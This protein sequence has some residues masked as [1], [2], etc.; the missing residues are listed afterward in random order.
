MTE[1]LRTLYPEIEPFETGMLDVGDG[2]VIYWERVGTKGAKPAVFLHGGPGG[3]IS[4]NHRRLFDPEALRRDPVRPARLRE[5]HAACRA[6]GQHDLASGRRHRAAAR[7]GRRRQMAGVRRLL[8]LDAGARLCRDASGARQRTRRARHLH[9]DQGRTRL[10]LS[11]RRLGDVPGQMGAVRRA[12][13]G[14]RARR[15]DGRLSQAADGHRPKAQVEAA[16]P[17]ASGRARR[18]RCC[19]S[20]RPATSSARTNSPS[21]SPASRT[22]SSSMPA[23]WRRGSCCAMRTSSRAFPASSCTAATTCRARRNM[24]GRCTRPGRTRSST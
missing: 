12:D 5:I 13:P 17:G 8:G 2:H 6:G 3:G 21:P 20:P 15:H 4:P 24:P 22:T 14:G 18:S 10:V 1:R 11:V 19:R 9:A 16:R 7:D 23:G